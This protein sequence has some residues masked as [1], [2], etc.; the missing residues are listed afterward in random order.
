MHRD[1][2]E[3]YEYLWMWSKNITYQTNQINL[4][5][6]FLDKKNKG[7]MENIYSFGCMN[8]LELQS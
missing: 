2:F 6:Y 1:E 8:R 3:E 5:N 4:I 7:I